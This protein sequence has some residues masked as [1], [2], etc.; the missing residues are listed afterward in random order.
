M[1]G[2]PR[3]RVIPKFGGGA[4]DLALAGF[5]GPEFGTNTGRQGT[6][7]PNDPE[8]VRQAS[9]RL[10]TLESTYGES[11]R[12]GYTGPTGYS[13]AKSYSTHLNAVTEAQNIRRTFEKR[14][15]LGVKFGGVSRTPS[16]P[17]PQ[18]MRPGSLR[19]INSGDIYGPST[20][21]YGADAALQ[22]KQRQLAIAGLDNAMQGARE[23]GE[24]PMIR[25]QGRNIESHGTIEDPFPYKQRIQRE[26]AAEL[27]NPATARGALSGQ[28]FN[29]KL[30]QSY[31]QNVLPAE[32]GAHSRLGVADINRS[33]D[34]YTADQRTRVAGIQALID[35]LEAG[36][37][38]PTEL[39]DDEIA[40]LE[41]VQ[42]R[43]RTM[44][45]AP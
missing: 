21:T 7:D 18:H 14:G 15:P 1:I 10:G 23:A 11:L 42:R 45:G 40:E 13:D 22:Q 38:N 37:I 16:M 4:R 26:E 8:Q 24:S 39:T 34:Q 44:F 36:D 25:K 28:E 29:R 20:T 27:T 3:N 30:A 35:A 6:F 9:E 33:A 31:Q 41:D 12:P 32:I 5:S 2:P 43:A 19:V 17:L